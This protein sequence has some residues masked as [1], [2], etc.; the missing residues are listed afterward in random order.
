MDA[1][2]WD[3]QDGEDARWFAR[4]TAYRLLGR[5]RTLEDAWRQ[6]A[7]DGKG[8]RPPRQWYAV[9]GEWTWKERAAAWDVHQVTE[10]AER[11]AERRRQM[12]V[13][14]FGILAQKL[15]TLQE[16]KFS[17]RTFAEVLKIVFGE[18]RLEYGQVPVQKY[19]VTLTYDD[20]LSR[21]AAARG[22]DRD[23][24]KREVEAM[25]AGLG[26]EAP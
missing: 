4:F 13:D 7:T 25:L 12:L 16:Q 2:P 24:L 8:K 3:R 23:A 11:Q 14:A 1:H 19:E 5:R 21:I 17:P 22:V 9:A 6:E 10:D 26:I 15:P 18:Q 20:I